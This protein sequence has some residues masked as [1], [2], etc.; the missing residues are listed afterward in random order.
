MP[1]SLANVVHRITKC[2]D[3]KPIG[4]LITAKHQVGQ[5][6]AGELRAMAGQ[7]EGR[8]FNFNMGS[9][10]ACHFTNIATVS[11]RHPLGTTRAEFRLA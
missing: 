8:A 4:I 10:I 2:L 1:V 3:V 11:V 9:A 5:N 7:G 6:K